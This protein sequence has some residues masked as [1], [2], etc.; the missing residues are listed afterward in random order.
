MTP[1]SPRALL[2]AMFDAAIAA[3]AAVARC[4]PPHLPAPPQRPHDRRRRRQGVGG[5]G[6]ARRGRTGRARSTGLVVTRYGYAVPCERIEI[7]EA[8]HPVPD[9]A[10][11][12]GGAA[13]PRAGRR[14]RRRRPGAVPDL[15]RRLGAAGAAA[16]GAHARRQ[17]GGQPRAAADRG[18][19]IGE[20]NCVRRHLSAIKGGRLARGLRIRREVVTL[21]ISDVPGDDPIDIASGPTVA[22]PTTCAD[23]LDDPAPLRHRRCRRTSRRV[24]DSGRRRNAEA[25]RSAA[26]RASTTAMIATPQAALEAAA[27]RRARSRRHAAHPR[28]RDRRRGA[29][30]RQGAWPASRCRSRTHGAAVRAALRAALRRRDDGHRARHGPRRAQRRVPARRSRSR[31]TASPASTRSPATPTAS[32]AGGQSPARSLAPDTLARAWAAR[33]RAARRAR[34]QRRPRLLRRARRLGRHRPDAHQRQRLP[35]D[36]RRRSTAKR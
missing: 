28:R 15:R 6:A 13:H 14:A 34:R 11:R 31:S 7:V 9:A 36:P 35:R 3:R 19:T 18:A 26:R 20:M 27:A 25:R 2:R 4:L 8:A 10:G 17:A 1:A 5:D 22:D 16:A 23:A 12:D 30:R 32:T 21:L 33:P 24:L 29:R